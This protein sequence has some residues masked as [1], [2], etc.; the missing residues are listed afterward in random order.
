MGPRGAGIAM[1][2]GC[3]ASVAASDSVTGAAASPAEQLQRTDGLGPGLMDSCC[4]IGVGHEAGVL[5][6]CCSNRCCSKLI[7][8]YYILRNQLLWYVPG[9]CVESAEDASG[10]FALQG[11]CMLL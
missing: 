1:L 9:A 6:H 11:C 5:R 2:D 10:A 3:S 7:V 4:I 8:C